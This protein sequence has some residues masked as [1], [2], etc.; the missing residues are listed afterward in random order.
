[1]GYDARRLPSFEDDL[2]KYRSLRRSIQRGI[3]RIVE[4]PF[5]RSHPLGLGRWGDFRGKRSAHLRG[6]SL[7]IILAICEECIAENHLARNLPYC[8]D[9][10]RGQAEK[11]VVLMV[12][13]PHDAAYGRP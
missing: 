1:M 5:A 3:S 8:K 2:N 12:L 7:V 11:T 6:G 13:A 10:C 9:T 4:A